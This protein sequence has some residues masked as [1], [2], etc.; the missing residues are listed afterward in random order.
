LARRSL[1]TG[2]EGEQG[3]H[4]FHM[5][6]WLAVAALMVVTA[7]VATSIFLTPT[8]V[9]MNANASSELKAKEVTRV[10]NL[11]TVP[12]PSTSLD[13]GDPITPASVVTVRPLMTT[14]LML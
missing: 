11:A 8:A 7:P 6:M 2:Q 5:V 12:T 9:A 14:F 1:P 4:G 10:L 13:A 3:R